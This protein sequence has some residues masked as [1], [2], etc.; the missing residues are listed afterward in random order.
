MKVDQ[1]KFDELVEKF[2]SGVLP[3]MFKAGNDFFIVK[4]EVS[5]GYI[6]DPSRLQS[7]FSGAVEKIYV[8][9]FEMPDDPIL[10][11][12]PRGVKVLREKGVA[13]KIMKKI[14]Q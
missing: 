12:T 5:G 8:E 1:K 7:S 2:R 4:F 6:I 9:E 14:I 10:E 11:I 3:E 13:K